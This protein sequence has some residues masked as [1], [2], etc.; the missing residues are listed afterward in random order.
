MTFPP[1]FFPAFLILLLPPVF[2]AS[3]A[4][5]C[6]ARAALP[7]GVTHWYCPLQTNTEI[8]SGAPDPSQKGASQVQISGKAPYPGEDGGEDG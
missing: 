8:A 3:A 4:K 2:P 1:F 5:H 6:Q 7:L